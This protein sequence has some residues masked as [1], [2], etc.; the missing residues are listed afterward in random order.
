MVRQPSETL[1]TSADVDDRLDS[2]LLKIVGVVLLGSFTTL[3]D[4][5]I[6]SVAME[7]LATRFNTSLAS[8][9][10]VSTAYL[11]ALSAVIPLTGWAA[12]R[13]GTKTMWMVSLALFSGGSLLCGLAWSATSLIVFRVLQGLGGGMIMPLGQTLLVHAAG[14]KRL[15]RV[16][17]LI[18]IPAQLSPIL[19]PVLGGV[20][21][22]GPGWPWLFLINVPLCLLALGMSVGALPKDTPERGRSLDLIGLALLSPGLAVLVY[23]LSGVGRGTWGVSVVAPLV[24]GTLLI[25]AFVLYALRAKIEP[26]IDLR[27]FSRRAFT[28]PTTVMF[29]FGFCYFGPMFLLPLYFQQVRGHS[30]LEAGLLLAPQGVGALVAMLV[31]G[32]FTDRIGPR[33][34][35]ITGMAVTLLGTIAYTQVQADT[36]ETLL[37]LSLAVRGVGVGVAVAP[38]MTAAYIG[39]DRSAVSKA[40]SALNIIQRIGGSFGTAVLAVILQ[41]RLLANAKGPGGASAAYGYT[42]W[43]TLAF[44]AVALI[45]AF[46]IPRKADA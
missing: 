14:P 10:W 38:I 32:K 11:L 1:P 35:I 27:L 3:L 23:G 16:I 28:A 42:F 45:A 41:D 12:Q 46:F 19:G 29:F 17:T 21:V 31:L 34:L 8:I 37:G 13:F 20:L 7:T 43:W 26:V 9:Q 2:T 6:V 5:T 24:I 18:S 33:L 36:S 22:D 15:G 30:A 44:S 4:T 40:S 39:L 25:A